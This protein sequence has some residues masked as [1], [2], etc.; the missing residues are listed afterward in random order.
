MMLEL[1]P[2]QE[3]EMILTFLKAEADS[4]RFGDKV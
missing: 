4:S 3:C 1:G 2:A